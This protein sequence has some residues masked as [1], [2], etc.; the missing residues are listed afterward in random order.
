MAFGSSM[1]ENNKEGAVDSTQLWGMSVLTY[2]ACLF[3]F[4]SLDWLYL[5]RSWY[6]VSHKIS[7]HLLV[8]PT[9]ETESTSTGCNQW[10]SLVKIALKVPIVDRN[11]SLVYKFNHDNYRFIS[12]GLEFRLT[13]H[14]FIL[15]KAWKPLYF[16]RCICYHHHTSL[17]YPYQ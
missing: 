15:T 6:L 1:S 13:N 12:N 17:Y 11:R 4:S 9:S 14:S 2:V 8:L 16:N 3:M 5:H 7:P 10:L